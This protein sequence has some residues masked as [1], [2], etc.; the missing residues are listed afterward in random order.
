MSFFK[1]LGRDEVT[2]NELN[3]SKER[4]DIIWTF[5]PLLY[6]ANEGRVII[7]QEEEFGEVYI[8]KPRKQES[9]GRT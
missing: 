1:K 4:K 6:L 7:R 5:I 8:G 2:L 9:A 3:P